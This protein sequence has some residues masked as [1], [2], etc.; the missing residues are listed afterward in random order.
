MPFSTDT[1][2]KVINRA[3][4][5]PAVLANAGH[6][7]RP[8][9]VIMV[10]PA[11]FSIDYVIN[12]HMEGNVG[13]VDKEKALRQWGAVR[14]A[15]TRSGLTVHVL[16]GQ[17][18]MPDMVFSANHGLPYIDEQGNKHAIMSIMRSGHRRQEVPF[19]EQ[20]YRQNG[21]E[22]HHLDPIEIKAFEGMGDALWHPGRR[23]L[24]GGYGFRTSPKAYDFISTRYQVSVLTLELKEPAF[25]HL[26]TCMCILDEE[27]VLI[28]PQAFTADGLAL[29]REAFKTVLEAGPREAEVNFVC[30]AASDGKNVIIQQG[31]PSIVD[32]LKHLG[33]AVR[34]VETGEYIKSGGSVFCMKCMAW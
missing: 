7:P 24:W 27:T 25:Y 4:Q 26:D 2:V 31:S 33:F 19:A 21:Y 8:G 1:A 12:P 3:D 20:W 28:Y 17:P 18:K 13:K 34:E 10:E 16:A 9:Q 29:I 5:L 14:D 23:M 15:F 6:M 22:I 11:Y 32:Q 30:N